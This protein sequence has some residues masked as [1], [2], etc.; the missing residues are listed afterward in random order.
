VIC[1]CGKVWLFRCVIALFVVALFDVHN[2]TTAHRKKQTHEIYS[3]SGMR[4]LFRFGC[5]RL[6]ETR[7][8][9]RIYLAAYD[10]IE[11]K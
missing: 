11:S 7:L 3:K 10:D 8:T 2:N 5:F 6:D 9:R 4:I 1:C